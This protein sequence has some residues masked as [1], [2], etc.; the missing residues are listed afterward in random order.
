MAGTKKRRMALSQRPVETPIIG[1]LQITPQVVR[2]RYCRTTD[3]QKNGTHGPIRYYYCRR[4]C[5]PDGARSTF[6]VR[7]DWS[8]EHVLDASFL[9]GFRRAIVFGCGHS[10]RSYDFR[11]IQE[12]DLTIAINDAWRLFHERYIVPQISFSGDQSFW[13]KI[14]HEQNFWLQKNL[15]VALDH[16]KTPHGVF[17]APVCEIKGHWPASITDGL[18]WCQNSG[19]AAVSLADCLGLEEIELVGFDLDGSHITDDGADRSEHHAIFYQH[20]RDVAP[21]I[22]T[23]I[24]VHGGGRLAEVFGLDTEHPREGPCLSGSLAQAWPVRMG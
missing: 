13:K 12:S 21:L 14:K 2:C 20:W 17:R 10:A 11:S 9:R 7:V 8:V 3:V 22:R 19:I 4:C 6:S 24:K 16:D 23:P 15:V 18:R 5:D 1:P